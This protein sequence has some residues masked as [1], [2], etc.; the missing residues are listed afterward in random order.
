M[1][2]VRDDRRDG[3]KQTT[4]ATKEAWAQTLDEMSQLAAD[5][6]D[7][8]WEVHTA[9]A[10]HTDPVTRDMG[11]HDRFGLMHILPK[12]DWQTFEE[13]YDDGFTEFLVYGATVEQR[14]FAVTEF[15]DSDEKRSIM[16]AN[17]YELLRTRGLAENAEEAGV[18]YSYIKKID[19]TIVASFEHEEYEPLLGISDD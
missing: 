1:E 7:D 3:T 13:A 15:I 10:T 2:R 18:L 12:G 19:G 4:G 6:S 14:L 9:R 5:R 17:S 11:D 16:L 8:G